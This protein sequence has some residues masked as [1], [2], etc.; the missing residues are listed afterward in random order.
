MDNQE[1][2]D[3]VW[4]LLKQAKSV[5]PSP[6]FARNVVREA[7]LQ[8][9]EKGSLVTS[10]RSLFQ[11][12]VAVGLVA[13][14]VVAVAF[15]VLNRPFDGSVSG[16]PVASVETEE[17]DPASEYAEIEY[18]GELM[19]VADPATLSDDALADLLF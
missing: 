9:S 10:F 15:V 4:E 2:N 14:A 11:N 5:E 16:G 1:Q 7:R 6:F 13:T 18:L 8:E 19:A 12:R 17:F 3:P